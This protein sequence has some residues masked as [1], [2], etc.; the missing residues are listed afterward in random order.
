MK[1]KNSTARDLNT[2]FEKL[3]IRTNTDAILKQEVMSTISKIEHIATFI[4]LFTVKMIKTQTALI[5]DISDK[6]DLL[7]QNKN[8][9]NKKK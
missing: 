8:D 5:R 6:S 1:D 9:M 3:I 7:D 4:D 2:K